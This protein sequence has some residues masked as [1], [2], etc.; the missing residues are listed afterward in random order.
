[1]KVIFHHKNALI[2]GFCE[3]FGRQFSMPESDNS[4]ETAIAEAAPEFGLELGAAAVDAAVRFFDSVTAANALLHLVA[5][6][7]PGEFAVRHVLESMTLA[8]H[9]K[10]GAQIVDI[11]AGAGL[12]SIP[13]LIA[14]PD[15]SAVL[16][17][18]KPKKAEFL[19]GVLESLGLADRTL[20]VNRQFEETEFIPGAT[21]TCRAL[22]GFV[23]KLARIR[24][25]SRNAPMML[26]GGPNLR[27]EL[28]RLRIPFAETLLPRSEQRYLFVSG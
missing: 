20:V 17:E 1:M 10:P 14:R 19:V 24:K 3:I 8:A 18:S 11:G 22:D 16:I 26:F 28:V 2:P 21:V 6:C 5:P 9:L 12:P 4:F 7:S 13:C 15:V 25:W 27:D 23:K